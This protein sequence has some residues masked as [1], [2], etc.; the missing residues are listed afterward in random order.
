MLPHL[1]ISSSEK[2]ML[3]L[4]SLPARKFFLTLIRNA[5]WRN[6]LNSFCAP[7]LHFTDCSGNGP[8]G[9]LTDIDLFRK[10]R[11]SWMCVLRCI[12][13]VWSILH[14][15]LGVKEQYVTICCP[16]CTWDY[17]AEPVLQKTCPQALLATV[18]ALDGSERC[19]ESASPCV[20]HLL[21]CW[22]T[23]SFSQ[24]LSSISTFGCGWGA[25][26]S[27]VGVTRPLGSLRET[28]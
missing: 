19:S 2:I 3:L 12:G 26:H 16:F 4:D 21:I 11:W 18:W 14:F 20:N 22:L 8:S 1:I 25:A 9:L 13:E 23:H 28:T 15:I 6:E 27:I 5:W 10:L 24:Y 17:K 7:A